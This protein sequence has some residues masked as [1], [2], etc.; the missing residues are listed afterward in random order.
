MEHAGAG[1]NPFVSSIKVSLDETG[2]SRA[3]AVDILVPGVVTQWQDNICAFLQSNWTFT[4]ARWLDID[5]ETGTGG[6]QGPVSGHP[7]NA[8][9]AG[10][11]CPPQVAML[12]HLQCRHDRRQRHGR[13]FLPVVG[14]SD[15]D[16]NGLIGTT[17][18]SAWAGRVNGFRTDVADLSATGLESVAW[19][20]VHVES[21]DSDHD[22]DSWSSS[23][24]DTVT[25]DARVATQR[26][27]AR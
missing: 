18:T 12:F 14:E 24:V 25:V 15:V 1:G 9:S 6:F 21:H 19:R 3:D 8:G 20:V 5:S 26:R 11:M 13:L 2:I 7:V 23:D 27:R 10:S 17:A 4:G 16:N 22:P